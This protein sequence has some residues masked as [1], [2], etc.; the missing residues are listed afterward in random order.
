MFIQT[1]L[2]SFSLRLHHLRLMTHR[3]LPRF[4]DP[5]FGESDSETHD[6]GIVL[7]IGAGPFFWEVG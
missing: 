5:G 2:T 4:W 6:L 1:S 7:S 3:L